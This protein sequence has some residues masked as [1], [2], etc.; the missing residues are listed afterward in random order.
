MSSSPAQNHFARYV[1]QM[2]YPPMGEAGQRRLAASRALLC[3]VGGLGSVIANTLA[4]AGVGHLRLVDPDRVELNNLQR[5]VL[6]NEAD[7]A[8]GLPKVVASQ[9]KI[10]KINSQVEVEAIVAE[11][12]HT[13]IEALLDGVDMIVDGTDNFGTRFLLNDASLKYGVPWVYGGCVAAEGQTMTIL[14]GETPCLRCLL[15][16][17]PLPGTTPTC[18]TAG[19]IG[20]IVNVIASFEACEALKVLSGNRDRISRV[21]TVFEL[22]D[23]RIREIELDSLRETANCPTCSGQEF[24]WLEGKQPA[25]SHA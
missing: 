8:A 25:R 21:L 13:N 3:G 14:P 22:W 4:R 17:A 6:Y 9:N 1:R 10:A 23:N 11:V 5:Q 18:A 12:D 20:P 16:D 7:A 24:P 2:Q 19:V 15:G